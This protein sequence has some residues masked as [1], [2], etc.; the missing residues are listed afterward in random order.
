MLINNTKR[1]LEEILWSVWVSEIKKAHWQSP[2]WF[3][4][5]IQNNWSEDIRFLK[6]RD[7]SIVEWFDMTKAYVIKSWEERIFNCNS[8]KDVI[9]TT[10]SDYSEATLTI[11]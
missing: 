2:Y 9:L 10:T 5:V 3:W 8:L 7:H 11:F 1:N 4:L 6:T